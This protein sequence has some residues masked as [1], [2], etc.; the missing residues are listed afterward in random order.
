MARCV[1]MRCDA[2]LIRTVGV[3]SH[4][5]EEGTALLLIASG[6]SFLS[7]QSSI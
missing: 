3:E 4:H 7:M 5:G 6:R 1:E 2:S